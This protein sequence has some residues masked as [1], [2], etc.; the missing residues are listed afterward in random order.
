MESY[1][2]HAKICNFW[3]KIELKFIKRTKYV[4]FFTKLEKEG[5]L[6]V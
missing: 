3:V 2:F 1:N 4:K 5:S 6:G